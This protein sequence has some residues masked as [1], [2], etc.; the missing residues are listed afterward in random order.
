MP[1]V[2]S[3]KILAQNQKELLLNA[4][5]SLVE[6]NAIKISFTE[7]ELEEN[8]IKNAIFS[9]KNSVKAT[10]KKDLKIENCF[11]VGQKTSALLEE[12]GY[13]VKET[14]ANSEELARIIVEKYKGEKFLF[15]CGSKRRKE[16]PGILKKNEIAL[17][18]IEVYETHYNHKKFEGK[19]D[20]IMFFSPSAVKSYTQKNSLESTAF[21][22]GDTTA[23]EAKKHSNNIIIAT[24]PG[25]ENVIA[26]MVK[27]LKNK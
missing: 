25:I 16:L 4:G 8:K 27:Y 26:K 9:S 3:T 23:S 1:R 6:Y 11:C 5:I 20:G 2:L 24:S 10:G 7:F 14:A 12:K 18:E 15:F 13:S 21:C 22:I 19:F 17:K